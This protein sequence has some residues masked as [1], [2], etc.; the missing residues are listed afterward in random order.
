MKKVL[1]LKLKIRILKLIYIF[2]FYPPCP[3]FTT[4]FLPLYTVKLGFKGSVHQFQNAQNV[5]FLK[6]GIQQVFLFLKK[7]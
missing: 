5:R 3:T 7:N 1:F 4:V 6:L 2:R